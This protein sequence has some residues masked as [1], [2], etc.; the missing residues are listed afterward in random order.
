MSAKRTRSEF[1]HI[2]PVLNRLL[3]ECESTGGNQLE[4]IKQVWEQTVESGI[5]ENAQPAAINRTV[6]LI[7]VS[8]SPWLH[9][10]QFLK[11]DILAR[12][13]AAL[14]T[15]VIEDLLFKIGPLKNEG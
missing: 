3:K 4:H 11:K 6:L 5:N 2:G 10:L 9:Q 7:H 8:S 12:L 15:A 13:N 1:V 14:P